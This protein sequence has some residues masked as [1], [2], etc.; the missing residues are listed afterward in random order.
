M[1]RKPANAEKLGSRFWPKSA[2]FAKNV[3]S[4]VGCEN[5]GK[6]QILGLV[7]TGEL[8]ENGSSCTCFNER[9]LLTFELY[10]G[11]VRVRLGKLRATRLRDVV[12]M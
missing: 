12:Y 6:V 2:L 7:S 8:A 9:T 3:P 5:D 4:Y 1:R 10:K 11:L